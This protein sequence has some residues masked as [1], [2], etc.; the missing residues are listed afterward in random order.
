MKKLL[1]LLIGLMYI[2]I[3]FNA[4]ALDNGGFE[5]GNTTG[6]TE[7]VPTGAT[8]GVVSSHTVGRR[9]ALTASVDGSSATAMS[10][11][12]TTC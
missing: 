12:I 9:C 1:V 7:N 4:Y 8:I 2:G 11:P 5:T 6:W 10:V 3:S